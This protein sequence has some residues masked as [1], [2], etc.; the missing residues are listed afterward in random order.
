MIMEYGPNDKENIVN[1]LLDRYSEELFDYNSMHYF[2]HNIKRIVWTFL[3]HYLFSFFFYSLLFMD[4][5]VF[6]NA[7]KKK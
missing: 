1:T 4:P 2:V 5:L 7:K 3:H 6:G